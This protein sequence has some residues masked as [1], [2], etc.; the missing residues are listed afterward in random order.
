MGISEE[1]KELRALQLTLGVYLVVFA[2]KLAVYFMTGVMALM[3][4]AMSPEEMP[5]LISR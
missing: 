1:S 3:A 2:M 4:E 5:R